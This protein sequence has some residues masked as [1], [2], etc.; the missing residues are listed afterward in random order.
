MKNKVYT[1]VYSLLCTSQDGLLDALKTISS[2]GWD[3]IEAMGSNTGGLSKSEFKALIR[4]LNLDIIS[5]HA[6][7]DEYDMEFAQYMGAKYADIRMPHRAVTRDAVKA[8]AEELNKQAETLRKYGLKAVFHNHANEFFWAEGEEN[9]VRIYDLLM[10]YTDPALVGF[11]LDV[12]WAMRAG[13]DIVPYIKKYAGRFPLLHVKE[14]NKVGET[15]DEMEHFPKSIL[16]MAPQEQSGGR[17]VIKGAPKF[18]EEQFAALFA[19]R[20]WNVAL[21]EGLLNWS[22]IKD[23]AEAQGIQGYINERENYNIAGANGDP[24]ACSKLDYE[25]LRSL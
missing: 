2:I 1:Q 14:C 22:E 10:E 3:G 7:R 11:E 23:A 15:I 20:S 4:D 24:T 9:H 13:V 5:F 12:G 8:A 19:S 16:A 25:F 17:A 21:G 6:L 18:T